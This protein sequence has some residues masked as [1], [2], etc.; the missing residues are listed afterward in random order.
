MTIKS[1]LEGIEGYEDT[2]SRMEKDISF[3]D[4][5]AGWASCSISL[6]R[7]ADNLDSIYWLFAVAWITAFLAVGVIFGWLLE[8][9]K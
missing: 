7:I 8:T 5:A 2:V 3:V 4:T 9:S 6:K 1:T